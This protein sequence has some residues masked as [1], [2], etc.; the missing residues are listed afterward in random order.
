MFSL[1]ATMTQM[2][3]SKLPW[4]GETGMVDAAFLAKAASDLIRPVYYVAGPPA[5]VEAMRKS[6]DAAGVDDL[7]IRS[8]DFYGY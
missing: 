6:L 7:D 4:T 2:G 3:K 1:V 5:M 8:E